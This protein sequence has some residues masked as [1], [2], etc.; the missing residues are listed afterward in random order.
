MIIWLMRF[1]CLNT[2]PVHKKK[3]YLFTIGNYYDCVS[4]TLK[5]IARWDFPIVQ[6]SVDIRVIITHVH[7][8]KWPL[9]WPL[10]VNIKEL[11][12]RWRSII[13]PDRAKLTL[14]FLSF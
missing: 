6:I 9:I 2:T 12:R 4:V 7:K 3:S 13:V 11:Q 5:Q 14:S 8:I 1:S 10:L